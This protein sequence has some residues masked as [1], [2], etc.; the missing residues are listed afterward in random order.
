[1]EK[2]SRIYVN[3]N[4]NTNIQHRSNVLNRIQCNSLMDF[5]YPNKDHPSYLKEL[6]CYKWVCSPRGN[7]VDCHRLWESLYANSIP[8]V[9]DAINT[10]DFKRMG[11]PI[12]IVSDWSNITL[13]WLEEETLKLG[14]ICHSKLLFLDYWKELF[15]SM[16]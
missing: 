15:Y 3:V 7:G 9:D 16:L 11:L 8:L 4:I 2:K 5:V 6:S 12:I 10:Q 14:I 1:M 13:E